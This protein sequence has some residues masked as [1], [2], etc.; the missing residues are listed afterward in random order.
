MLRLCK[1]PPKDY[2]DDNPFAVWTNGYRVL[3]VDKH[4]IKGKIPADVAFQY[5]DNMR[6]AEIRKIYTYN[7]CHAVI[8]YYGHIAGYTEIFEC[9]ADPIIKAE[10]EGALKEISLALQTEYGFSKDEIHG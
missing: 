2:S 3:Y 4:A 10:A 8:S 9:L 7:M 6:A 1:K 5:I